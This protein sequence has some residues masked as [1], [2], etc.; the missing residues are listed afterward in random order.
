MVVKWWQKRRQAA[1]QRKV[2]MHLYRSALAYGDY[3]SAM[4]YHLW[5]T[6]K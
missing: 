5:A 1:L 6:M 4:Q 3:R 2:Y